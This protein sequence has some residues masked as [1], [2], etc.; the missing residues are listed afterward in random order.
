MVFKEK[1]EIYCAICCIFLF[2]N[3]EIHKS[4]FQI[5]TSLLYSHLL[6]QSTELTCSKGKASGPQYVIF[7]TIFII[8]NCSMH[9]T[10]SRYAASPLPFP[11]S[12]G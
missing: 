2:R 12:L 3:C 10:G 7:W 11:F 6:C 9:F 8:I 5:E 1:V 4:S